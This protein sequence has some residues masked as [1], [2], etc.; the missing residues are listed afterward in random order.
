MLTGVYD[1]LLQSSPEIKAFMAENGLKSVS[2]LETYFE[3]RVLGL[4]RQVGRNYIVWQVRMIR[5][6][7]YRCCPPCMQ[8]YAH[9]PKVLQ[10]KSY[11]QESSAE[12]VW[13]W[14]IGA[15]HGELSM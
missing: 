8:K 12:A 7:F 15:E 13:A 10:N 6:L 3:G 1:V 11:R 5:L 14:S 4:A 9:C 2:E